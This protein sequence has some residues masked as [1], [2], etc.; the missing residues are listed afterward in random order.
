MYQSV[1]NAAH[2]SFKILTRFNKMVLNID[3]ETE[4]AYETCRTAVENLGYSYAWFGYINNSSAKSV[5]HIQSFG[6]VVDP[7]DIIKLTWEDTEDGS[8]PVGRA[9]RKCQTI[10][11]KKVDADNLSGQ[12]NNFIRK[13]N[14]CFTISL[15]VMNANYAIGVL[16]IHSNHTDSLTSIQEKEAL[17]ELANILAQRIAT[18]RLKKENDSLKK[19]ILDFEKNYNSLFNEDLAGDFI[20]S[21]EGRIKKCNN[22][23]AKILGYDSIVEIISINLYSFLFNQSDK[24]LFLKE[25][26]E[27]K[28]LKHYSLELKSKTGK[29][30]TV[31]QNI[32]G[33][34]DNTGKITEITGYIFDISG[35]Q[36]SQVKL[37]L[38]SKAVQQCPA[39]IVITDTEGNIEYVNP[40]FTELTGYTAEEVMGKNP[41]I[42]K[43]GL[44]DKQTYTDLWKT[45]TAGKE[46][47]GDFRN[48]KKD[49]S[50]YWE[51]ASISPIINSNGIITNYVAVKEDITEKKEITEQ[52][53]EAREKA[54]VSDKLKTEFLSQMSHE[55]RTPLNIVLSNYYFIKDILEEN[56]MLNDELVSAINNIDKGGR[57]IIRTIELILSMAE[58]NTGSYTR[59]HEKTDLFADVIED[60]YLEYKHL[61]SPKKL[62][63]ILLKDTSNTEVVTDRYAARQILLQILDNAAKFTEKGSITIRVDRTAEEE[64]RIK[65]EDTGVGISEEFMPSIFDLFTQ[66]EHGYTRNYDGNGLGLAFVKKMSELN[67][68]KVSVESKKGV[69][70]TFTMVFPK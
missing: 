16:N 54:Q 50:L 7:S 35:F 42:L 70:S 53:L 67:N 44:T 18:I 24:D 57:R 8:Q 27:K 46:W 65:V 69:G 59:L 34:F 6:K 66:E 15:P 4:A 10:L 21:P 56:N 62:Q 37:N 64:L 9:I 31:L 14:F 58:L 38:F 25:L 29:K 60:L 36:N 52:L 32:T 12:W 1:D 20:S 41:R 40:K 19:R 47:R 13:N 26:E 61:T 28:S 45:I 51:L 23:F 55:I 43:S 48:R 68:I 30:I 11:S 3:S 22:E 2:N 63:I 33:R 5:F 49:G 17:E 39:S